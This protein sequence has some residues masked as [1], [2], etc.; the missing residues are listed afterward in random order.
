MLIGTVQGDLHDIGKN[1][2]AMMLKG[3]G[4]KVTDLGVD[5]PTDTFVQT[6]NSETTP[7]VLALS[8]LL[9]TTM[10]TLKTVVDAV[11]K[12]NP[13][14]KIMVG[15]APV[16]QAFAQQIG[17]HGYAADAVTAVEVCKSFYS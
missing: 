12:V 17:A 3:S 11:S 14:A 6:L 5:V 4:F 2:V 13:Q 9:T 10:P 8:A 15:G 1:L 16:T 7:T